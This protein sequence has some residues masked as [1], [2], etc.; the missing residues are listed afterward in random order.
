[1]RREEIVE[2]LVEAGVLAT[3]SDGDVSGLSDAFHDA[4]DEWTAEFEDRQRTLADRFDGDVA[5]LLADVAADD[6]AF[7]GTYVA[8]D[9]H[10]A[11]LAHEHRV[12]LVLALDSLRSPGVPDEGAPDGFLPVQGRHLPAIA[13]LHPAAVVYVWREDCP[14]CDQVREDLEALDDV[15]PERVARFAVF[16]PDCAAFLQSAYD[17]VGGPTTLFF[18]DGSV[19]ARLVGAAHPDALERE[20]RLVGEAV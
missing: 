15:A 13:A 17:V 1:M 4:E 3:D 20:L 2:R 7:V 9:E 14:P 18:E 19:A 8:I 11:E 10:V 5:T 16:G 6:P 12:R